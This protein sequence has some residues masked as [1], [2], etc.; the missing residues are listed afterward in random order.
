VRHGTGSQ[1]MKP[2]RSPVL[3]G[4][5]CLLLA[6][7]GSSSYDAGATKAEEIY[8][9][10]APKEAASQGGRIMTEIESALEEAEDKQAWWDGFCDRGEE[11]WLER[12]EKMN[13]AVDR[14]VVDPDQIEAMFDQ[15][16]AGFQE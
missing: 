2:R 1:T 3:A 5:A 15:M 8:G 7:C 12:A 13:D 14:Q 10:M 6:G 16:R 9:E 11:I 4:L